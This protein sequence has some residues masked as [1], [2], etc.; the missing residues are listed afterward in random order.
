MINRFIKDILDQE[1]RGVY[2]YTN[3]SSINILYRNVKK[4]E[5]ENMYANIAIDLYDNNILDKRYIDSKDI[6]KLRYYLSN[7]DII[8]DEN[9][10]KYIELRDFTNSYYSKIY[11]NS[12]ENSTTIIKYAYNII[13]HIHITNQ[14]SILNIDCDVIHYNADLILTDID[15]SYDIVDVPY[16]KITDIRKTIEVNKSGGFKV[17]GYHKN[18]QLI[19]EI[20]EIKVEIREDNL[21]L[22]LSQ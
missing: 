3:K 13:N 17:R 19:N 8:K 20:N 12:Q 1:Y 5:F 15:I 6:N 16:Y 4:M 18:K 2:C 11:R 21:K 14:Y 10:E 9:F 22:L 7:R